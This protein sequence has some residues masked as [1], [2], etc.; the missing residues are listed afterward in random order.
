MG[1]TEWIIV[2]VV[3]VLVVAALALSEWQRFELRGGGRWLVVPLLAFS[4]A[5]AWRASPTLIFL[6]VLAGLLVL[7][8]AANRTRAGQLRLAGLADFA[9]SAM[10]AGL[11]AL[12]GALILTLNNIRWRTIPRTR[13]SRSGVQA[14][15]A[16]VAVNWSWS[17][18]VPTARAKTRTRC[19]LSLGALPRASSATSSR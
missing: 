2:V 5:L 13:A 6:D 9:W 19:F 15:C 17:G 3:V 16:S 7:A 8:L 4:A 10:L 18:A 14:R 11:N 1:T 12:F